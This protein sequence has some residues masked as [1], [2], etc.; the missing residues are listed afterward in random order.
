MSVARYKI[1]YKRHVNSPL[2]SELYST[3]QIKNKV[4]GAMTF[5]ITTLSIMG[6][7]GYTQVAAFL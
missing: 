5:S 7:N 1:M 6:K 4:L 3:L 2:A